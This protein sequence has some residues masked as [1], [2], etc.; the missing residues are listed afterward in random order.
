MA[1]AAGGPEGTTAD[2]AHRP[3]LAG[4]RV[5]DVGT[6]ISAPF[7][8]G[9]LGDLG[10]DVI[11]VEDPRGGDFMRTIG[12]F[13]PTGGDGPGYSLWW[14]VEGRGRRGVTLDLRRPEGQEL[15]RRLA[16]TADVVCE[17]FRP[18]AME[19]W[20][21]GPDDC[22]PRLVW[23]RISVF[24]QDGPNAGRTGLDRMGIAYGGLLHLT[25]YPDR[26]PV[27]PGL[28]ISDY[29]TGTFAASAVAAALYRRDGPDGT[30]RGG[31]VDASLTESVLRILEWTIAAQDRLGITRGREGNRMANSAPLDN[32]PT[33]D[34]S[35]VCIVAGSDTNFRRLCAAMGRPALADDPAWSTLAQ[36]RR[37]PTRS[38]TS[39]PPGRRAAARPRSR[40]RASP[41]RCRW[42]PPTRPPTSWP[43][44]TW[45]PAATW[46]RWTIPWPA[47][48]ASRPPSPASTG[49]PR[50]PHGPRRSWASTTTR[51]GATWWAC[52][53]TSSGGTGPMAS[54]DPRATGRRHIAVLAPLPLE[55]DA[56]VAAFG[57]EAS[58][59]GDTW[60]GR[61]G[62]ARVTAVR[63][64][65]GPDVAAEVTVRLLDGPPPPDGP[66]THVAM[67]GI[68]GGLDP[69][70]AVGTVLHPVHVVD[71]GTGA[72]YRHRAIP[73][74]SR[75]GTLVTT[76]E[77][78]FDEDLS[79]RLLAD[80]AVGVDME[81]AAVAGVCE[82]RGC[83]GRCTGPSATGGSTVCWIPGSWRSPRRTVR[84]T[85][86]D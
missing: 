58:A 13:A 7:C 34:G 76:A 31:V 32:Y 64:G 45:P 19:K 40:R 75:F 3:P 43:T 54:S 46:S 51:C 69:D 61:C 47:R 23:A 50:P 29:L 78:H 70:V 21:I 82:D 10:A 71:H 77:V 60:R 83:P 55:L 25:G 1:G 57:L 86:T 24:G 63:T 6:R 62:E 4:V 22:D 8:A 85:S 39:W 14:A 68:C 35:T 37:G 17:N 59:D 5:I 53:P 84:S 16:A 66:I 30:G 28:S 20:G 33:A 79:R 9:L 52:P 48:T 15:F 12:P 18:G 49:G 2:G 26:P 67:V 42:P 41:T 44:P 38:T 27:R 72:S 65:M 74:T 36:R 73:G 81:S 56:V 11:K 80:G